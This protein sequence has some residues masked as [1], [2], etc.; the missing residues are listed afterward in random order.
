MPTIQPFRGLRYDL[1]HVG[2]LSDVVTPPYDVISP[3]FQDEL[4]KK[5]PANF[6]RLELN[7]EEPGDNDQ[8]N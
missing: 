4:Y 7:R 5:H 2:S 1:G 3:A 8:S 6:I